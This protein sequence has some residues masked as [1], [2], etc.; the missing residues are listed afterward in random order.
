MPSGLFII[1]VVGGE[2]LEW[3]VTDRESAFAVHAGG[4]ETQRKTERERQ[5][6]RQLGRDAPSDNRPQKAHR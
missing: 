4:R 1:H 2:K 5:H 6:Q 3:E